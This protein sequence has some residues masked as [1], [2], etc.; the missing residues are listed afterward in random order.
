MYTRHSKLCFSTPSETCDQ[1]IRNVKLAHTSPH[2]VANI[3][4][5]IGLDHH[6]NLITGETIKG[7]INESIAINS[8]LGWII[9]ENY[10]NKE[11]VVQRCSVKNVFLKISQNFHKK[12]LCQSLFFNKVADLRSA[13]LL[14]KRLW[15]RCLSVDFAKFL[16][17]PF[18]AEHL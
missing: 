18:L 15:H 17:T 8:V 5:L 2:E 11:A 12:H 13:T 1:K 3:N 7:K 14:K 6:Y 16:R 4:I 9:C 10:Q